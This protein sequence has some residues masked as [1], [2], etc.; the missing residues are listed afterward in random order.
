VDVLQVESDLGREVAVA[1]AGSDLLTNIDEL[2]VRNLATI[3]IIFNGL[4]RKEHKH[5]A[6][7]RRMHIDG[8]E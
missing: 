5:K 7:Q 4:Q 6:I 8:H 2:D 1:V 3:F